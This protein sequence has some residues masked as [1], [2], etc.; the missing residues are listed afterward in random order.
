MDRP[1]RLGL[2]E[3]FPERDGCPCGTGEG[4]FGSRARHAYWHL[5]WDRGVP[6]PSG[7]YWWDSVV[8]L[9]G[10]SS[11]REI[12]IAYKLGRLFQREQHY[13][14]PMV[15]EARSWHRSGLLTTVH[16]AVHHERAVG[17]VISEPA[18]R[19]G[20]WD[21]SAEEVR[22]DILSTE[23]VP[24]VAG[25]F[26]C[27]SYRRHGLAT[28][29]VSALAEDANLPVKDLV[30]GPPFSTAGRELALSLADGGPIRIGR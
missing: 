29:L 28:A 18:M 25:V 15:P 11:V 21:G 4:Y 22:F 13:D 19:W 30:W 17:I 12:K 27:R 1:D 14:F 23:P 6:L 24:V 26:V 20:S 3:K 8:M 2:A 10:E 7:V 5:E 9:T 16:I